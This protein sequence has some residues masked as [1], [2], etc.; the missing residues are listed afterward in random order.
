[1][2]AGFKNKSASQS[3]AFPTGSVPAGSYLQFLAG[4]V[5]IPF[6][7]LKLFLRKSQEN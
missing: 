4:F 2:Q 1:V 3:Y 6:I 7:K 5:F